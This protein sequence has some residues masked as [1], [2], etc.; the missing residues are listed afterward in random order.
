MK[1]ATSHNSRADFKPEKEATL[2]PRWV[3]GLSATSLKGWLREGYTYTSGHDEGDLRLGNNPKKGC[4]M[5]SLLE[6]PRMAL[7]WLE[8][9]LWTIG[10]GQAASDSSSGLARRFP[11]AQGG[12][13]PTTESQEQQLT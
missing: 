5:L 2:D 11:V 6:G 12:R 1:N 4:W 9:G 8:W 13:T 3:K 7:G 10:L